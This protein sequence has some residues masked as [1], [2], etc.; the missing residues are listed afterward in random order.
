[1]ASLA[2]RTLRGASRMILQT[3]SSQCGRIAS[4]A[5]SPKLQTT[6]A[7]QQV[8]GFSLVKQAQKQFAVGISRTVSACAM[9]TT[10]SPLATSGSLIC[11]ASSSDVLEGS[12]SDDEGLVIE[13]LNNELDDL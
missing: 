8:A 5:G 9:I 13:A 4:Q 6:R 11:S 7:L 2:G 10:A 3:A 1:M 12:A